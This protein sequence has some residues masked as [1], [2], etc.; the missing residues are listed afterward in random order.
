[1]AGTSGNILAALLGGVGAGAQG[2]AGVKLKQKQEEDENRRLREKMGLAGMIGDMSRR[3]VNAGDL[4][5][6][7]SLAQQPGGMEN[8]EGIRQSFAT[9]SPKGNIPM[10]PVAAAE[11]ER[12]TKI[13]GAPYRPRPSV[14]GKAKTP[15]DVYKEAVLDTRTQSQQMFGGALARMDPTGDEYKTLRANEI[16]PMERKALTMN[17]VNRWMANFPNN[18]P[19]KQDEVRKVLGVK[20]DVDAYLEAVQAQ[21]GAPVVPDDPNANFPAIPGFTAF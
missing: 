14:T 16:E 18:A 11:G 21:S 2:Y 15:A 13:M 1:M 12:V 9:S 10:A 20:F 8:L 4:N 19:P 6:I 17:Y 5:F 3:N 7:L